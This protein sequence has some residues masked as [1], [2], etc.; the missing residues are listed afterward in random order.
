[1]EMYTIK[2][3]CVLS[4]LLLDLAGCA[5]KKY[6]MRMTPVQSE[7]QEFIYNEG[8]ETVVS[9][10]TH[11]VSLA[12]YKLLNNPSSNT[13]YILFVQNL[14]EIPINVSSELVKVFLKEKQK[15]ERKQESSVK[16]TDLSFLKPREIKVRSYSELM[17]AIEEEE[18]SRKRAARIAAAFG[19][20]N[21]SASAYST[22]TTYSSGSTYGTYNGYSTSPYSRNVYGNYSGSYSGSS[23]TTTYD[24]AKAQLLASQN[25]QNFRNN[26]DA[27]A[28]N[29]RSQRQ[30]IESL[31]MKSQTLLPG[32]SHGGL[33]VTDTTELSELNEG[34]FEIEVSL[35]GE[36]H[37]FVVSRDKYQSEI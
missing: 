35:E 22:S 32:Q 21:A 19:A 27:I 12:P 10:K 5:G 3:L 36:K 18:A 20:F 33:I 15:V 9:R 24:P 8:K 14:G 6:Y 16:S 23:T 13:S 17:L 2:R 30:L 37:I 31:V 34:Y 25:S 29:A 1:M 11:F 7:G 4:L 28:S 26:L